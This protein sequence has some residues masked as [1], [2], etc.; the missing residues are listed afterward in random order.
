MNF[1][2]AVL[3]VTAA[4]FRG[5]A[6]GLFSVASRVIFISLLSI[7]RVLYRVRDCSS[8]FR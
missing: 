2:I 3:G 8:Q 5:D 4:V 1:A 6:V 7:S